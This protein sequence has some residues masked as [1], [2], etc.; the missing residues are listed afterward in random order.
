[1]TLNYV[2]DG[3]ADAPWLVFSN[4]L[5][6]D[7]TL[8]DDQVRALSGAWQIL[9]YDFR[10]HGQSE[11]AP[12]ARHDART[13]ADDLLSV[14]DAA[15]ADKV[16]HVGVSMGALAGLAAAAQSPRRFAAM[17]CCNARLNSTAL[18]AVDL[19]A[20]ADCARR[21][22]MD[23]LVEPTIHKWFGVARIALDDA[24]RGRIAAMIAATG[25]SDFAAYAD[26]MKEYDLEMTTVEMAAPLLLLAGSDDGNIPQTF[27]MLAERHPHLGYA[28]IDGAGHLPNIHAPQ[29]FNARLAEFLAASRD[30]TPADL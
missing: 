20:R 15:G 16:C 1:M 29:A 2:V 17:V 19:A 12:A 6:T 18:S 27:R 7:L 30:L 9:R 14:M 8:W 10:G 3:P 23:A 21:D 4:S 22:G 5:A 13:L 24:V 11:T 28:Q 25:A 26:G